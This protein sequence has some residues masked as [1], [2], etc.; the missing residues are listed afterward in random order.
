MVASYQSITAFELKSLIQS[1]RQIEGRCGSSAG[2]LCA[3]VLDWVVCFCRCRARFRWSHRH[4]WDGY[5]VGE[6]ALES[7]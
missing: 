5:D 2:I 4:L 7:D 6:N 3:S 1:G